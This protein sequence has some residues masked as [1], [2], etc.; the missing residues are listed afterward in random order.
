MPGRT[1]RDWFDEA[2]KCYVEG[3]Q[4]CAW[5][6]GSYRVYQIQ[7]PGLTTYYCH[8]CDFRAEHDKGKGDYS[9]VPGERTPPAG[10]STMLQFEI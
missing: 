4:G 10:R 2:A 5:C 3:H 6:G 8:C 9:H 7:K 1:S